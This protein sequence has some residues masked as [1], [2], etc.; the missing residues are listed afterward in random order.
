MFISAVVTVRNEG[1]N[2]RALLESLVHQEQPFEVVIVD[3]FSEDDTRDIV[4]EFSKKYPFVRLYKKG[5]TRGVGRNYGVKK[6]KG[7][8]VA[9]VDGDCIADPNW[10]AEMRKGARHSDVVAGKTLNIGYGPYVDLGRVELYHK[11]FDLTYPS[12]NLCYRTSLFK[13]VGGF[14]EVFITAEDIDLN[15]RAVNTGAS[16]HYSEKALVEAK[17]R[18]TFFGFAK[19]AFWN[20]YGRKQLTLK[21]GRL[22]GKY[23]PTAFLSHSF[24]MWYFIRLGLALLGYMVAKFIEPNR[25]D[26]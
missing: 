5:G 26:K 25:Q 11:G 16:V 14:D 17:A 7:E 19:Q 15:F 1:K 23:K 8:Y 24:S 22:W 12:C 13:K 6:A 18:D 3:S 9:F 20:G 21:H 4:R 10:I 2:I